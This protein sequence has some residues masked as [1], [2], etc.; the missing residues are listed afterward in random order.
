M[1]LK[2]S[3]LA[4]ALLI[5]VT[6]TSNAQDL[7]LKLGKIPGP[8]LQMTIYSEDSSAVAVVLGDYGK[9]EF[10]DV[11]NVSIERHVR[12]KILK[13]E[14]VDWGNYEI[15]VYSRDMPL[16]RG[17]TYNIEDGKEVEYKVKR[18]HQQRKEITDDF[19]ITT[20]T[21]PN[22]KVGSVIDLKYS[23]TSYDLVKP[24]DDWIFQ[25]TIPTREQ[26]L[27]IFVPEYLQF[28][29][30]MK[31]YE[32]I[33]SNSE[34]TGNRTMRIGT[35]SVPV[36][37]EHLVYYAHNIPGLRQERF[38]TTLEDY[39]S[40]L[41]M[42]IDRIQF[43]GR[44]PAAILKKEW[45]ELEDKVM[46]DEDFGG[47]IKGNRNTRELAAAITG[48]AETNEEKIAAIVN[49][50]KSQFTWNGYYGIY[51]FTPTNELLATREGSVGDI[52]LLMIHLLREAGVSTHP[53]LL[54]TRA[55]GRINPFFPQEDDCNFVIA[56]AMLDDERYL[57]LDATHDNYPLGMLPFRCRNGNGRIL[58]GGG[59]RWIPLTNGERNG[60]TYKGALTLAEDG[61]A[62]GDLSLET[63]GYMAVDL[64][65]TLEE[66][67]SEVRQN[68]LT[69]DHNG[70]EFS[71]YEYN[72]AV[73]AE[74]KFSESMKV[75]TTDAAMAAGDRIYFNTLVGLGLTENPFNTEIRR[76][77]VNLG[78]P[79]DHNVLLQ[80]N[81]PEGYEVEEAPENQA[82]ALPNNGGTFRLTV[83]PGNGSIT[84]ISK[85]QLAKEEYQIT[86][87]H[88]LRE[89][90]NVVIAKE[91]QQIVLKK[92]EN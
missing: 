78:A 24:V 20:V 61:S 84:I 25:R 53:V 59:G 51:G 73:A 63:T 56:C 23:Y 89:F 40:T 33:A 5:G 17:G 87:Y 9:V 67:G 54:S 34:G 3:L 1:R 75:S 43:P 77:P 52:N 37:T 12:I 76:Y 57:L 60:V 72:S 68:D 41:S 90:V 62:H 22:V 45:P 49:Y 83:I 6:I 70:W 79:Q 14:G 66:D 16:V 10:M 27:H 13:T 65:E 28:D 81:L 7:K 39:R 4:I 55:H 92:K 64:E 38:I 58:I 31:G 30:R 36:L 44:P 69:G 48:N 86:E 8:D 21:F 11:Y 2:S 18:E 88:A 26:A 32:Q 80:I 85:M 50:V 91:D 35:N 82:F 29:F 74:G 42:E 47:R 19:Y 46:K 71:D 15:P